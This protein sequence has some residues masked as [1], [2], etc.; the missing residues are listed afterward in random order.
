M[1]EG[2]GFPVHK[3]CTMERVAKDSPLTIIITA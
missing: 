1:L 3:S 2:F